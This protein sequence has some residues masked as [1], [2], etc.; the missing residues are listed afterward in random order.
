MLLDIE[1]DL[2]RLE[3]AVKVRLVLITKET[4]I[5]K[6]YVVEA[7]ERE[8]GKFLVKSGGGKKGGR[9][10]D[11]ATRRAVIKHLED[12]GN[13]SL[14]VYQIVAPVQHEWKR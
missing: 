13:V 8:V 3:D 6:P 11:A 2:K 10:L 14:V 12:G 7:Y 1:K 4:A 5:T 9:R